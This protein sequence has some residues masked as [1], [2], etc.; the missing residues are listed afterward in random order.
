[1]SKSNGSAL[2][3]S[4]ARDRL[5]R[6]LDR[7]N[8][9]SLVPH[10]TAE[11]LQAI[12]QTRGLDACGALVACAT[13]EQLTSVF[14]LDLWRGAAAGDDERFDAHRFAD[15]LELLADMDER[16]AADT[17]AAIDVNLFVGGLS[18]HI[19][20]FDVASFAPV[21]PS[22][23]EPW[24]LR[25]K[26]TDAQEYE[27][28]GYLLRARRSDALDAIVA[29]LSALEMHR[30]ERFRDVMSGCRRL[31]NR[32]FERDGL[33]GL[34]LATEQRMHDLSVARDERR[35]AR[36]YLS[37]AEARA[38]LVMARAPRHHRVERNP[39]AVA[40]HR[41]AA[42][43]AATEDAG[44]HARDVH[45]TIDPGIAAHVH[46]IEDV[47]MEITLGSSRPRGLLTGEVSA[48]SHLAVIQRLMAHLQHTHAPA[49]DERAWEL[50]FVTNAL[51][52][53]CAS[54]TRPFTAEEA[55]AAAVSTCNLGLEHWPER[56]PALEGRHADGAALPDDFLERHDL[57]TAFE[58]GWSTLH[59]DVS[60]L[61][62]QRLL[63]TIEALRCT[64]PD[65]LLA[66]HALARRVRTHRDT[67]WLASEALDVI[68]IL[69]M[70]AWTSLLGLF[71]ECPVVPHALTA[72]VEGRTG[73]I[74]AKA[75]DFIATKDQLEVIRA[76]LTRLPDLLSA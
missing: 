34:L 16:A 36:G 17:A 64:D 49:Y 43:A 15:W 74:D 42:E 3:A 9:A 73:A 6:L 24:D 27:L 29:V 72:V 57:V 76:F 61:V 50:A 14:D 25:A 58:V 60:Q 10:L 46:V 48:P 66:L 52:S 37:A 30:P 33:D 13:P 35:S 45:A 26:P 1:M 68:A 54:Q 5:A 55:S 71:G 70:P 56:W 12:I 44:R 59:Q 41:Q 4:A 65:A 23:D 7:S 8:L 38:F 19:R 67:P 31:S 62:V 32:G 75:F 53:G 63:A 2:A 47:V 21:A 22:D 39:I 11:T 20:V 51:M 69:D 18:R 40:A 28:A